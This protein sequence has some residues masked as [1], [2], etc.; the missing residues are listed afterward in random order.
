MNKKSKIKARLKSLHTIILNLDKYTQMHM[1]LLLILLTLSW[2]LAQAVQLQGAKSNRLQEGIAK[3][4]IRF[5]VVANSDSD[6]D[7]Q[8][9][10]QVKDAL[11]EALGPYLKEAKDIDE[12]EDIIN[13]M[14]P[15]IQKLAG[16]VI[17]EKGYKY[18]VTATL[19]PSYFPTKMY[20]DYTFPPGYYEALQIRIGDGQGKNWWCVMFP[21]LCLVDETYSI[22]D[23]ESEE[24]LKHLLTE[25]EFEELKSKKT[26][27]KIKFKIIESLKKLFE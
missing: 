25:E 24:E 23:E 4:I 12:A 3:E 2:I 8:L 19:S 11:V 7:Q 21:P 14:L 5:H 17:N 6:D 9:K 18:A 22:V 20:G 26:P 27:I 1:S 16:N 13:N 15:Q 10:Y